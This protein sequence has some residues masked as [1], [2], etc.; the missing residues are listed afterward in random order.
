MLIFGLALSI[1]LMAV[2][3]N[4]IAKLLER[5]NWIAYVG[6]TVISFVAVQMIWRGT[7]EV[8]DVF[9]RVGWISF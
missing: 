1:L 3:S 4:Y 9:Q 2:A 6:L 8:G 5:Y 7:A